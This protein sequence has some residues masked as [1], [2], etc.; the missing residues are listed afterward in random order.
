[1]CWGLGGDEDWEK[2]RCDFSPVIFISLVSREGVVRGLERTTVRFL[3]GDYWFSKVPYF[4]LR[5]SRIY[6]MKTQAYYN[7]FESDVE[8]R[9]YKILLGL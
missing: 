3:A 9:K 6:R 7:V 4:G 8:I 2:P 5:S 1:M